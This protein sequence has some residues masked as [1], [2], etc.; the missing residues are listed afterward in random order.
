MLRWTLAA[1]NIK[2]FYLRYQDLYNPQSDFLPSMKSTPQLA[3]V[4]PW[5]Y[6]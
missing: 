2:D 6:L 1:L 3:S 5:W 4:L